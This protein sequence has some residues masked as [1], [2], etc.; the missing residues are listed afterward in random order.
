MFGFIERKPDG[1]TFLEGYFHGTNQM[2]HDQ[3]SAGTYCGRREGLKKM[4]GASLSHRAFDRYADEVRRI[5]RLM[6]GRPLKRPALPIWLGFALT[7]PKHRNKDA[8]AW[9]LPAKAVTDALPSA[10]LIVSDRKD[11]AGVVGTVCMTAD[12]SATLWGWLGSKYGPKDTG[13]I[14]M[15]WSDR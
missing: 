5:R 12:E 9:Y 2:L 10:G 13:L 11:V 15:W 3:R 1:W 7:G 14:C 6:V 4:L 8:D